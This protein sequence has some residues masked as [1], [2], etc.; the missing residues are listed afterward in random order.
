MGIYSFSFYY[1]LN[2]KVIASHFVHS[3]EKFLAVLTTGIRFFFIND[4]NLKKQ[5]IDA[6]L[7]RFKSLKI[8]P[9]LMI[10]PLLQSIAQSDILV[11][12]SFLKK[13]FGICDHLILAVLDHDLSFLDGVISWSESSSE[14]IKY[15]F[16]FLSFFSSLFVF[17]LSVTKL[18]MVTLVDFLH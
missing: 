14:L 1:N 18:S 12:K 2:I 16:I 6:K 8:L 11:Q 15:L 9:R 5:V 10:F 3:R 7:F 13:C 4:L 17:D